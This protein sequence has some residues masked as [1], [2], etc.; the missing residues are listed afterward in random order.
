[1][2][3]ISIRLL[4]NLNSLIKFFIRKNVNVHICLEYKEVLI[5]RF[6]KFKI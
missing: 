3:N 2:F 4:M 6:L 1:M 5:L